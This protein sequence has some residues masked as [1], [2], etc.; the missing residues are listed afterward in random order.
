MLLEPIPNPPKK[1]LLGNILDVGTVTPI[2]DLMA[3][4]REMGPIFQLDMMGKPFNVVWGAD[5]VDEV[6]DEKRF[7]KSV[8]GNL[9]KVR[10]ISGDGLFTAYTTE[11][12]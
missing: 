6:M 12:N 11:P 7:D 2:Q 3:L 4:A 9:R 1:P 10:D 8:R 5:L